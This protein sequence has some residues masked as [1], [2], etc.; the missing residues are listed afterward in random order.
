MAHITREDHDALNATLTV[1]LTPEDY[2]QQYKKVLA[3]QAQ[4]TPMKGFRKGKIPKG[5]MQ[6]MYG[7]QLMAAV[8]QSLVQE[9]L[10]EY[11]EVNDFSIIGQPLPLVEDMPSIDPKNVVDYVFKFGLGLEPKFEVK[12]VDKSDTYTS[13]RVIVDE[14]EV[15]EILDNMRRRHGNI[16][17]G[18]E[19]IEED[20]LSVT[21]RELDAEGQR[22]VEGVESE[23]TLAINRIDEAIREDFIGAKPGDIMIVDPYLLEKNI[24]EKDLRRYILNTDEEEI[25]NQYELTVEKINHLIPA[26]LDDEFFADAFNQFDAVT[27]EDEAREVI[28]KSIRS[29]FEGMANNVLYF[30]IIE[31]LNEINDAELPDAFI[32]RWLLSINDEATTEMLEKKYNKIQ[33]ELRWNMIKNKLLKKYE[34][35]I[36]EQQVANSFLQQLVE[37]FGKQPWMTEEFLQNWVSRSM[38]NEEQVN[39]KVTELSMMAV[40]TRIREE[41]T[42]VEEDVTKEELEALNANTRASKIQEEEE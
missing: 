33:W 31:H 9:Q 37:N 23:T 35:K 16:E 25:G 34:I 8:L 4:K 42:L 38:E 11:R 26:E 3:E 15:T 6:K 29:Q 18:T 13:Y 14:E 27:N 39:E 40:L 19:A 24:K 22:V 20:T 30:N 32:K 5:V 10:D 41:V 21:L 2:L 7:R 28:R 12:G 1:T 36:T 17:E